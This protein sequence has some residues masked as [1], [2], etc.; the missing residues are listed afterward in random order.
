VEL[1]DLRQIFLAAVRSNWVRDNE[2][3]VM[4]EKQNAPLKKTTAVHAGS[5]CSDA[6]ELADRITRRRARRRG[7]G[8]LRCG[9]SLRMENF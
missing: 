1:I 4:S 9:D 3:K 6:G 8:D 2:R 7:G 5:D